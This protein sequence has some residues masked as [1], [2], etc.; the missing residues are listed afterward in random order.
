MGN[1]SINQ[2]S[3]NATRSR[4]ACVH[5][6]SLSGSNSAAAAVAV[7]DDDNS[8]HKADSSPP[9]LTDFSNVVEALHNAVD[10]IR[11][12]NGLAPVARPG[13]RRFDVCLPPVPRP[14]LRRF[15]VCLP[16]RPW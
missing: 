5:P 9:V 8:S 16:W 7:L 14:G 10:A 6:S 13:P 12:Q 11:A 15:D 3:N 2:A 1:N 4:C